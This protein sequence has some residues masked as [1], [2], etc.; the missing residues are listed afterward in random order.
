VNLVVPEATNAAWQDYFWWQT[1]DKKTQRRTNQL[2]EGTLRDPF[3]GIG[4]PEALLVAADR[5]CESVGLC[6]GSRADCGDCVSISLL[7]TLVDT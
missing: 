1:Q 7:I 6:G 3:N 2:I 4:K 5:R